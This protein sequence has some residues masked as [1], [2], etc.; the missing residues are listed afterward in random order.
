MSTPTDPLYSLQSYL[1]GDWGINLGDVW[2][3]YTGDGVVVA[4]HDQG[5]DF[6]HPDLDD[7]LDT[8]RSFNAWT[9]GPGGMPLDP[10]APLD[11]D[12]HGTAV[13]GIIAA[14]RNG[15]GVVGIAYNATL[16][17]YYDPLLLE[18]VPIAVANAR[19]R[20]AAEA[21]VVNGSWG[22]GNT[23][24]F[25]DP[26]TAFLD[27]FGS[28]EYAKAL[29]ATRDFAAENGRDGLGTILV[30]SAGNAYGTGD[31]TNLHSFQNNRWTIT[32][33]ATGV[34]SGDITDFSSQGATILVGA[35]GDFI[36]TTDRTGPDGYDEKGDY[37]AFNGTSA[38]API[39]SGIVALMLEA[40]PNLGWRDVQEILA[41]SARTA[42]A[43]RNDQTN[44]ASNWNGGGLT[45]NHDV[46]FGLVDAHAA[47]RLAESWGGPART[48]ANEISVSASASPGLAIPD[49]DANGV[50]A[51][52]K[53]TDRIE[54]DRVE[55]AVNITHSFIGD[56]QIVLIS[57]D[58]TESV[59][60]D[61]PGL[62]DFTRF[63]SNQQN[64]DFTFGTVHNW[65]ETGEGLWR[66][67]VRDLAGRDAT[68]ILNS[69]SL[70]LYGD[71]AS[72]DDTYIY[73]DEFGTLDDDA[74]RQTLDDRN[75]VDTINGAAL[76]GATVIDLLNGV[77][78]IAGRR[79]TMA[80]RTVIEN[81]IG[82]DGNDQLTGG[83]GANKLSGGRGNDILRGGAG[84]D[85]LDGGAGS[86]LVSYYYSSVGVAANLATGTGSGGDAE[87]DT[88]SGIENVNGSAGADTLTGSDGANVLNGWA[89]KDALIGGGGA[90]RF[91]LSF[92]SHS[93]I[94]ANA[95]EITGFLRGEGDKIDLS[96]IDADTTLAGN[97]AFRFIGSALYNHRA[98]ELRF[99]VTDPD[100]TTV[101][102][103]VDG[104]GVSD[105]HIRLTRSIKLETGDFVL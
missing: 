51:T 60:L 6:D 13:A 30:Q 57:P 64:I 95:D 24:R 1:T 103:D 7:N 87:G 35:P 56:L 59:L 66:L 62:G 98:G 4:V 8:D 91:Q 12:D 55:V 93:V 94:G 10:D 42:P 45:V 34:L 49:S 19:A 100:T 84:A 32:V 40:N 96:P 92:I 70:S 74:R 29:A 25:G 65:G 28:A 18:T 88:Y 83:S 22:F 80:D 50:T 75:G 63:G 61:R 101:A 85:V 102:G 11:F 81:V 5:I 53:I 38:A 43:C 104:D 79:L 72:P 52:L 78:T 39:V 37:T 33:G 90:D 68:G 58:G 99:A 67:T 73:T 2:D 54:I 86:D 15:E 41:Y 82:G 16:L 21:D 44:G 20:A 76:T 26:N 27:D 77:A 47:V 71:T 36:F 17:S 9:G 89:G 31:N 14:E 48:S 105:F 23:F 69:W 3:E 97:Q 46:G